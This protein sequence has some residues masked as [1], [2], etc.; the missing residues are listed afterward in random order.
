MLSRIKNIYTKPF[1]NETRSIVEIAIYKSLSIAILI[2]YKF[3]YYTPLK[4]TKKLINQE[5]K[6]IK[7]KNKSAF[8]FANGPSMS[9]ID[10]RKIDQLC[11][12][13]NFDLIAINSYLS[14]SA[15][16]AKPTY[17]VFADNIHFNNPSGQYLLDIQ[18]CQE[19]NI[20]YFAPAKYCKNEIE[21]RYAY[22]SICNIDSPNISNILNP[23]GYYGVTAFFAL[24]LATMLEYK[25]IYI[26]GFDN[27]YFLDFEVLNNGE[28]CIRHKHYYDKEGETTIKCLYNSTSEF[29]MD[30]HRHFAFLEKII[31][32]NPQIVNVAKNT[33]LNKAI[34]DFS[35]DIYLNPCEDKK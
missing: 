21:H 3:Y 10:L 9:D 30:I 12:S 16:I 14:K 22:C 2:F 27:S 34:R 28:M 5:T 26:C 23:A 19:L 18:K 31:S 20:T 32:K 17:A 33:Y 4:R 24:S 8:V 35:L 11:K 6:T 29:F 1:L 25:K 7:N 15:N 13:G